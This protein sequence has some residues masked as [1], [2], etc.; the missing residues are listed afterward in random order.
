MS[1]KIE[2]TTLL[3]LRLASMHNNMKSAQSKPHDTYHY[4]KSR[5]SKTTI[6]TKTTNDKMSNNIQ[7]YLK[8]LTV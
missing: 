1:R 6:A 4:G 2:K 5:P 8:V 7:V 3:S